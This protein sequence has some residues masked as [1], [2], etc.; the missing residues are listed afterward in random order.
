MLQK[1]FNLQNKQYHFFSCF[2][3]IDDV[4]RSFGHKDHFHTSKRISKRERKK[5]LLQ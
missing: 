2:L 1:T 3:N 4:F 5:T